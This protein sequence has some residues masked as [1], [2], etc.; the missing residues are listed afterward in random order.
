MRSFF[1]TTAR[2]RQGCSL[3]ALATALLAAPALAEEA[4]ETAAPEEGKVHILKGLLVTSTAEETAAVGGGVSFVSK[5][6]IE[7]FAATDVNRVLRVVP[8]CRSRK[9]TAT[10]F[11]PIS[12]FAARATT[13]TTRSW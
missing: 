4:A 8:G 1:S 6:E 13:A 9:R 3:L 10:D 7:K 11:A 5:E 2:L 12:A